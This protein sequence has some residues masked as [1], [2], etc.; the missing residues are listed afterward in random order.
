MNVQT[1]NGQ[2]FRTYQPL[3]LFGNHI[4]SADAF[5]EKLKIMGLEH[6][7]VKDSHSVP[8]PDDDEDDFNEWLRK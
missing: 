7:I 8:A 1:F 2:R 6:L 5:R 4:E 3:E